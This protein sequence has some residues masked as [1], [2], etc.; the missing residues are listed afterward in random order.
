[1]SMTPEDI[2][3]IK[4]AHAESLERLCQGERPGINPEPIIACLAGMALV[5]L[6]AAVAIVVGI[7]ITDWLASL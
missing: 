5:L 7:R 2:A 6:F 4:Q 1:V 3:R